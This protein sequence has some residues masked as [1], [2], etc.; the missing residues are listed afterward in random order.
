M[1]NPRRCRIAQLIQEALNYQGF[2]S[3]G[4]IVTTF[5]LLSLSVL[6]K[7]C[8]DMSHTSM[9]SF[10]LVLDGVLLNLSE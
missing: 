9:G 7:P 10:P 1:I 5:G 3:P 2:L 8:F 4:R 6:V